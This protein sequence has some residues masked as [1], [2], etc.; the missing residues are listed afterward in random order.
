MHGGQQTRSW[1]SRAEYTDDKRVSCGE[2]VR[3]NRSLL[4]PDLPPDRIFDIG[5]DGAAD[6]GGVDAC[7]RGNQLAD[8]RLL[9][10]PHRSGDFGH[11]RLD[12]C[13]A[14]FTAQKVGGRGRSAVYQS[15]RVPE[16][17]VWK[18]VRNRCNNPKNEHYQWYGARGI[19]VCE[20]WDSY[21]NF[22]ADM[23]PRPSNKHSI[24]RVNNDGNYE[25]ANCK[26]ATKLE[27]SRNRRGVYTSQED[28]KIR[29][30]IALGLNFP[31][32]A[33]YVGKGRASV[34]AR[35]YYLGLKSGQRPPGYKSHC[36]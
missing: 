6:T 5:R 4:D 24:E 11:H 1:P 3:T 23:G 14:H 10:D 8:Q 28:D 21:E 18:S 30:A 7:E 32:M 12:Q 25:P 33:E 29:E 17:S 9:R 22:I 35:T 20:R 26:W 34:Q 16:Y 2:G 27:Q 13:H 15:K 19:K 36:N 31:Q